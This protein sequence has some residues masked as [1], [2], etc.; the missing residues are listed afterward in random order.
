MLSTFSIARRRF[1]AFAVAA[2]VLGAGACKDSTSPEEEPEVVTMRI[3]PAGGSAV[4]VNSTGVVTG[5][6]SVPAAGSRAFTVEFL[7]A[8]GQPDPVVD[9]TTFQVSVAPAAGMTFTRTGPFA[10]TLTAGAAGTVAV[11]LGLLHIEENH[12]DFGPFT[13]NVTVTAP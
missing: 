10:G 4:T 3:T 9:G 13:V 7:N 6:L 5:T 1:A 12:N 8:A 2:L 11:Q